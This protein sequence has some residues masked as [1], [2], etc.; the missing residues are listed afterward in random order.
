V[1]QY[2]SRQGVITVQYLLGKYGSLQK[3][4]IFVSVPQAYKMSSYIT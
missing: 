1:K 3:Y 2:I 4:G